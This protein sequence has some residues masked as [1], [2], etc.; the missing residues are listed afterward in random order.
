MCASDRWQ[1]E[2]GQYVKGLK[3][4]LAPSE[5]RYLIEPPAAMALPPGGVGYRD[6]EDW[7]KG[8]A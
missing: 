1:K 5:E 2:D 6:M 7:K 8:I 3:G 4:W